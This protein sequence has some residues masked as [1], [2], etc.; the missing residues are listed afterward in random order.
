MGCNS[1]S[2]TSGKKV[3]IQAPQE[4]GNAK[5]DE[6]LPLTVRQRFNIMKSWK[7]IARNI[8]ETGI[9]MFLR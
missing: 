1:S 8:E 5:F 4:N 9:L 6:R 7:G 2:I 3:V